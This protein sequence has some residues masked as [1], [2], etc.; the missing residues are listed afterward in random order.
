MSYL[1]SWPW[2]RW[3]EP[4]PCVHYDIASDVIFWSNV[5]LISNILHYGF[6][7]GGLCPDLMPADDIAS[8]VFRFIFS[9]SCSHL[10]YM[11]LFSYLHVI[12]IKKCMHRC[13]LFNVLCF[14]LH[15]LIMFHFSFSLSLI[16]CITL[17]RGRVAAAQRP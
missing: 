16:Y 1:T 6:D 13:P 11:Y 2:F 8:N 14:M 17:N 5:F 10:I 4:L 12:L 7:A 15:Y 3:L 9:P